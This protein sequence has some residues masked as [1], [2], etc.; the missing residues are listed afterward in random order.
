[1]NAI[2]FSGNPLDAPASG[3]AIALGSARKR[4]RAFIC[5]SGRTVL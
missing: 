5:L 3:A 1:M 4:S 2:P